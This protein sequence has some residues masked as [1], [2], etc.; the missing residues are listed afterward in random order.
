MTNSTTTNP[1]RTNAT[2]EPLRTTARDGLGRLRIA[3][4][5]WW[6]TLLAIALAALTWGIDVTA[7]GRVLPLLPLLYVV[8]AVVRRRAASW[9]ILR[10]QPARLPRPAPAGRGR[11]DV[12]IVAVAAAVTAGRVAVAGPAGASCCCRPP[13]WSCSPA[14]PL[15]G[16][17]VAPEVARYVLAAG[18]LAHGVWDLVHLR[19]HAV[20]SRFYAQWCG[21]VDIVMAAEL[22]IGA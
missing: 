12:V 15:L 17:T 7:A 20:V 6:P 16:L 8:A 11:P 4:G 5:R 14:S 3:L 22:L 1:T 9:P 13:G 10:R 21:V 18:W 19:R 2:L